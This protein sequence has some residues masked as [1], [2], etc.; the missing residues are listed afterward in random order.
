MDR[1][2]Y[3]LVCVLG[4]GAFVAGAGC[5]GAFHRRGI[6]PEPPTS[7]EGKPAGFSS[8]PQQFQVPNAPGQPTGPMGNQGGASAPGGLYGNPGSA[9]T[10]E[11]SPPMGDAPTSNPGNASDTRGRMGE[12]GAPPAPL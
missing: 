5:H 11:S 4:L 12:P 3:K 1:S 7:R 10:I 8:D 9:P 6:P 2:P